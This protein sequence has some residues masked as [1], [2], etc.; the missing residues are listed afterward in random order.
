MA[1]L[2]Y[3]A[4]DET[5]RAKQII[6]AARPDRLRFEV[7]SPFGAVFV[8]AASHGRLAA[9]ARDEGTIYRG[10]ASAEN[11]ERYTSVDLPVSAA[12]D[13]L[14]GTPPMSAEGQPVVSRDEDAIKFWEGLPRGGARVTWFTGE[15][16]PARY[17]EQNAD[18]QVV[19]RALFER[20]ADV[21][22][23]RLPTQ[24]SIETPMLQRRVA[25]ELRDPEVNPTL[26][27]PLF[28][29]D[30]PRGTKEIDLDET[31]N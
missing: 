28:A 4:P 16:D 29:L 31:L 22:G 18:G 12:V 2:E 21:G 23:V 5:R 13:L 24:L 26:A 1:R 15:L 25:I 3:S 11:L 9:Y 19:L 30:T 7:L 6:L 20:F 14:L 17:E 10:A 8:L 27:D